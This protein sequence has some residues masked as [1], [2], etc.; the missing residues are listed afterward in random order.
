MDQNLA[1]PATAI[2]VLGAYVAVLLGRLVGRRVRWHLAGSTF[3]WAM[4]AAIAW[5]VVRNLPIFPVLRSGLS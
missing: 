4:T 1:I 2:L 5:M 3:Q